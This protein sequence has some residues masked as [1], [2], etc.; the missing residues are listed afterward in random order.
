MTTTP[1]AAR[2]AIRVHGTPIPQ[3]SKGARVAKG[4]AILFDTNADRL[5]PWRETIRAEAADTWTYRDTLTGPIRVWLRFAFERPASH[6]RTGKNAHLL[7]DRAPRFPIGSQHGD[8]DKLTRAVFDAL[9][10]AEVW[11][12]DRLVVKHTVEKYFA[13]ED[14]YAPAEPGVD[15][16][17]EEL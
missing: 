4:R 10:D 9:T 2:I 17:L 3:G 15:I 7:R 5:K 6:Y 16:I 13:G 11:T 12:D 14:E 8:S 1:L